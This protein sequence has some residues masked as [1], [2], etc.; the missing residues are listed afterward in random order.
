MNSLSFTRNLVKGRVAETVF[1]QML[2]NAD[3][4]TVLEFGY[5]KIIP[6]LLQ[7]NHGHE[8]PVIETLR[9]APD[10][11]IINTETKE[12]RLVEVKY[13]RQLVD[14]NI[15]TCAEKMHASW[16]PSYLFVATLE[17]F[18]FDEVSKII[19]NNGRISPLVHK[20]I[21]AEVQEEYLKIL[22][23]FEEDN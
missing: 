1:S 12:V 8:D 13:R 15:K 3:C 6:D 14:S 23:D 18:Y 5:E 9:T 16:N 22:R 19:E 21:P 7:Y 4:F 20:S 17:G 2:R 11:A 10:F